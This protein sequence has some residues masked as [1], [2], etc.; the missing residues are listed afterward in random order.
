MNIP[1]NLAPEIFHPTRCNNIL[2]F[3][4]H[5]CNES[6]MESISLPA[7]LVNLAAI[8]E[9]TANLIASSDNL[10]KAI[11]GTVSTLKRD[12]TVALLEMVLNNT[13]TSLSTIKN[14]KNETVL[15]C[16]CK[17][18]S[19][20]CVAVILDVARNRGEL[21]DLI[22]RRTDDGGT[23]L[24]KPAF[25]TTKRSAAIAEL[26]ITAAGNQASEL[27]LLPYFNG[28]TALF[29]AVMMYCKEEAGLS[30]I[31]AL[32]Q[33][34]GDRA[35]ELIQLAAT[36]SISPLAWAIQEGFTEVVTYLE[37]YLQGER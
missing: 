32:V 12:A 25:S 26:I 15:D 10:L 16:A 17:C 33:G 20:N 27:V 18:E 5:L 2:Y 9:Y 30:V 13:N 24:F 28:R 36:G 37:S 14:E 8:P 21:H 6:P 29:I 7:N 3:L 22:F 4:I 35:A 1:K 11:Y 19:R 23:A 34:A 31:K